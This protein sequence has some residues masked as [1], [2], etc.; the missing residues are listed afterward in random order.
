[1]EE[2]TRGRRLRAVNKVR[3]NDFGQRKARKREKETTEKDR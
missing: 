3:R 2:E 1:V